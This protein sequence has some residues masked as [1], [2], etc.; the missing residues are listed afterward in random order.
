MSKKIDLSDI[1]E[2]DLD[3]TSSFTDLMTKKQRKNRINSSDIDEMINEDGHAECVC[4]FCNDK[5]DFSKE[6]LEQIRDS[7]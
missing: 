4:H 2:N 1:K 6:E 3:E 7:K 5:Y